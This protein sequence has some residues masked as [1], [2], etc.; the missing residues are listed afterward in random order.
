MDLVL[1]GARYYIGDRAVS[2][3]APRVREA[4]RSTLTFINTLKEDLMK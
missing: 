2:I 1:F 4:I 3:H